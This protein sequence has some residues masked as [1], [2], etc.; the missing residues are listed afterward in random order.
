[1]ELHQALKGLKG[2][3][4]DP[5]T[6]AALGCFADVCH[7]ALIC[8]KRQ[9]QV[10]T[11]SNPVKMDADIEAIE[12]LFPWTEPVTYEIIV[13]GTKEAFESNGGTIYTDGI[14]DKEW[15]IEQARKINKAFA[16]K[17]QSSD[18]EFIEIYLTPAKN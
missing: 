14:V 6:C 18:R 13:Y 17:V 15:A 16:V 4:L 3:T 5:V 11:G 2:K 8:L 9:G 10:V 7:K 1:M 12:E